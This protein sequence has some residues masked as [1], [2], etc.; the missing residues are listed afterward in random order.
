VFV[1]H[2]TLLQ[3][4]CLVGAHQKPN[5]QKHPATKLSVV[6]IS[7]QHDHDVPSN[8]IDFSEYQHPQECSSKKLS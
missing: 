7:M 2:Y 5:A 4:G 8:S 1:T 6:A 3:L